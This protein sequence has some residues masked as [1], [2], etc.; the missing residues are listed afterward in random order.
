MLLGPLFRLR[1]HGSLRGLLAAGLGRRVAQTAHP[2]EFNTQGVDPS[3]L[4]L[5]PGN[6]GELDYAGW[7]P[8]PDNPYN[9]R[10]VT[11]FLPQGYELPPAS[12]ERLARE[13][14]LQKPLTGALR[15]RTHKGDL[16][17]EFPDPAE[18]PAP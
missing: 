6:D 14:R 18:E 9:G 10:S 4:G 13:L 5:D 15:V 16:L 1:R 3:T 12:V 17:L 11:I 8:R 2:Y 7:T